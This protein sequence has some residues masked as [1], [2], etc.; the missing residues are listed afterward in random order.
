M[1]PVLH[2]FSLGTCFLITAKARNRASQRKMPPSKL[3]QN[4]LELVGICP[5]D[6]HIATCSLN[7]GNIL[8]YPGNLLWLHGASARTLGTMNLKCAA[9]EMHESSGF[10]ASSIALLAAGRPL[11]V[12]C[13]VS[14][15]AVCVRIGPYYWPT[16]L[17][18][19]LQF[20]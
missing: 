11:H 9:H 15:P 12:S 5:P 6:D 16:S 2:Q 3:R 8:Q 17:Q 1:L 14:N 19:S 4:Y 20:C 10:S 13:F 7:I 18:L